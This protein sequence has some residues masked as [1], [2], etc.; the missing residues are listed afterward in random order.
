MSTLDTSSTVHQTPAAM[1]Q[2]RESVEPWAKAP[3]FLI[4]DASLSALQRL[5]L[6]DLLD[7]R[8]RGKAY[9]VVKRATL[10]ADLGV[11][12]STLDRAIAGLVESGRIEAR[13]SGRAVHYYPAESSI[14]LG[15]SRQKCYVRVVKSDDSNKQESLEIESK[16][17]SSASE[18]T[19]EPSEEQK[20]SAAAAVNGKLGGRPR[21][22]DDQVT[23][24]TLRRRKAVDEKR[25][26]L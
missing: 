20:K 18:R 22:P 6:I 21:L 9:A 23:P 16:Q 8:G 15:L 19:S 26:K 2:H 17:A 10:A 12:L 4:R 3:R 24:A 14:L 5:L 13:R 25:K 1:E 11:T 7:R